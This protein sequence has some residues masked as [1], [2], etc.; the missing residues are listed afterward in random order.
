MLRQEESGPEKKALI[1][2]SPESVDFATGTTPEQLEEG[3]LG[4]YTDSK[5]EEDFYSTSLDALTA[6]NTKIIN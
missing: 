2:K 3:L 6:L 5:E 4:A 1:K